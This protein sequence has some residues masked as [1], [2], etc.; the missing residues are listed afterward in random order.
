[1]GKLLDRLATR[2]W[3]LWLAC[4]A[5]ALSWTSSTRDYRLAVWPI[6]LVIGAVAAV[7][8]LDQLVRHAPLH[9]ALKSQGL[10]FAPGPGDPLLDAL[11]LI[12]VALLA[13][14]L[15]QGADV[16]ISLPLVLS[17]L[18]PAMLKRRTDEQVFLRS[19]Q[20]AE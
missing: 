7:V 15:S 13:I 16:S 8:I 2:P 12:S 1:M 19:L 5:W 4:I 11:R 6:I 9:K 17:A 3:V 18:L 14:L 10:K 20:P